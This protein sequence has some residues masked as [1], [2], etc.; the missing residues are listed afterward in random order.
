M[1][2]TFAACVSG[3]WIRTWRS[4][5]NSNPSRLFALIGFSDLSRSCAS[6]VAVAQFSV[7][8]LVGTISAA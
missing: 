6:L 5:S 1:L 2:I 8:M 4:M 3:T 7:R